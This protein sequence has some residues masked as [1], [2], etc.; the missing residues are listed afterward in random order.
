[1]ITIQIEID[2]CLHIP[3]YEELPA[4]AV[5]SLFIQVDEVSPSRK[6]PV[7]TEKAVHSHP[8]PLIERYQKKRFRSAPSMAD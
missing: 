2:S 6:E 8:P 5:P 7:A 4:A 3:F 1:M